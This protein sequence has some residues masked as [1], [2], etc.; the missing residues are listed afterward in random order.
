MKK[1][2]TALAVFSLASLGGCAATPEEMAQFRA[3][4][5]GLN[6]TAQNIQANAQQAQLV[7]GQIAQQTNA[8]QQEWNQRQADGTIVHCIKVGIYITCK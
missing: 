2:I 6:S 7:N 5:D 1:I 8:Q 4:L 3:S